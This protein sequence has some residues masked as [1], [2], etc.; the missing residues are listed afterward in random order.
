MYESELNYSILVVS[1]ISGQY[2]SELATHLA[3]LSYQVKQ[4][5]Q[6]SQR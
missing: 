3:S 2:A 5:G 6:K 4:A 1:L